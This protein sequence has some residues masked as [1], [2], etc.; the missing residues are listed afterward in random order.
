MNQGRKIQRIYVGDNKIRSI[1][2]GENQ[3]FGVPPEVADPVDPSEDVYAVRFS[4]DNDRVETTYNPNETDLGSGMTMC[5]WYYVESFDQRALVG[6]WAGWG[7]PR[8]HLG[9]HTDTKVQTAFGSAMAST[10]GPDNNTNEWYFLAMRFDA[11]RLRVYLNADEIANRPA[12]FSGTNSNNFAMGSI[13]THHFRGKVKDVR[14]Y[15]RSIS[16]S[17]LDDLYN[18]VHVSSGLIHHWPVNEG[19]GTTVEDVVG[20]EDGSFESNTEWV[21]LDDYPWNL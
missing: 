6:S 16:L 3:F 5:G 2:Y 7:T 20:G 15:N 11:S 9:F 10:A 21:E 4:S 14:I 18:G 17:E 8:F 13:H 12:F 1:Y 19:E